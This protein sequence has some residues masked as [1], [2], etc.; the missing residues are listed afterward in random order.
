[1]KK[2]IILGITLGLIL[3]SLI[4]GC[5]DGENG[6]NGEELEP[7]PDFTLTSIDNDM[8][9]LSDFEG[10]VVVLDFMYVACQYCDDEM[11]HLKEIYSNYGSNQVVIITIDIF[12]GD[13]EEELRTFKNQYGDDWIY[14]LD[15]DNVKTKYGVDPVPMIV[16]VDKEGNIAFQKVGYEESDNETFSSEIDKL[17]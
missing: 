2:L 16:I 15:T 7:A 1:M 8:F 6:E 4:S 11:E 14:A 5:L 3:T 10:K 17:L 13:T 9:N 12:E